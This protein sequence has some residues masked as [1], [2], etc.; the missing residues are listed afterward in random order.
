MKTMRIDVTN[1]T[2]VKSISALIV[3]ALIS[4]IAAGSFNQTS[5]QRLTRH[6][7]ANNWAAQQNSNNPQASAAFNAAR[8]L[9]DDAQWA[10]AEA[11]FNQYVAQ[12]PK[13]ENL[14]AATYWVAYAEYQL[15]NYDKCKVT[16]EKLLKTYDK[17]SWKQDAEMLLAQVPGVVTPKAATIAI[18]TDVAPVS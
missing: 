9:I 14:D 4:V 13:E 10:K 5:A 12:Y 8:D 16:V 3:A 18:T 11:A 1:I 17:T 2:S 15:K 7:R 6:P